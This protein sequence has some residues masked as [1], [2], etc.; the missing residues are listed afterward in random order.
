[1]QLTLAEADPTNVNL[2]SSFIQ[3]VHNVV[4]DLVSA[5]VFLWKNLLEQLSSQALNFLSVLLTNVSL[6][7]T[8]SCSSF[9]PG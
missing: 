1:M 8:S 6:T 7:L 4:V 9:S 2:L 5:L 3:L